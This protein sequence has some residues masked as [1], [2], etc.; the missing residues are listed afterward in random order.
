MTLKQTI[1]RTL[2]R[3]GYDLV[4]PKWLLGESFAHHLRTLFRQ[5][6]ITCV[7]DVGANRGQYRA[8]V[9]QHVEYA[10]WVVSF[11]PAAHLVAALNDAA[12]HDAR[13]DIHPYALGRSDT[14]A[15]FN[16]ARGDVLSSFL[17]PSGLSWSHAHDQ[18]IDHVERVPVRRLDT[19]WF[20]FAQRYPMGA[21][22]LKL[23]T[24]GFD[25]EAL[26]G[27]GG[28]LRQISALQTELS[29]QPL[30]QGMPTATE[31][32]TQ[33]Q[34]QGFALSGL[35]PVVTDDHSR[36]IEADGVFVRA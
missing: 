24:Q 36:I 10:G 17:Q 15:D 12:I 20:D 28:C 32:I 26:A 33:L 13:W 2:R 1:R 3:T 11:E 25:T 22:Y 34:Q 5:H 14:T 23:D 4:R 30:Y 7:L 19:L 8:Y 9:R 31:V 6:Q 16:V 35:F 29:F 18:V 27:A 21:T